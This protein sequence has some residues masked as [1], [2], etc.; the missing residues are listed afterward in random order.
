MSIGSS[1]VLA[2]IGAVL[3]F[4][5]DY[6]VSGFDISTAGIILMIAGVVGLVLSLIVQNRRRTSSVVT[7]DNLGHVQ[8]TESRSDVPPVV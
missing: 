8:R 5:V 3:Y 1:I 4:A 7:Q 2:V 6:Q